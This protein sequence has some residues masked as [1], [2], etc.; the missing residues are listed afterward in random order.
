LKRGAI[1][2]YNDP[3]I[4]SLPRMRHWP[5]LKMNSTPLSA[6]YL[7]SQDCVLI[8]TNHSAYNY[9]E[10][11]AQSQLVV[12]TRNATCEVADRSKIIRA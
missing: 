10:I 2:T 1:V 12:D 11:V 8:A 6:E 4:P 7:S 9:E 3:H 5:H